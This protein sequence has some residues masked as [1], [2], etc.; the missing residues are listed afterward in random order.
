LFAAWFLICL[1]PISLLLLTL[2]AMTRMPGRSY[3]GGAPPLTE[4]Q[5]AMAG[6]M[7]AGLMELA[8]GIGPRHLLGREA[9]LDRAV[10]W[11]DGELAAMGY[12]VH[13]ERFEVEGQQ[14]A[15]LLAQRPGTGASPRC[16]VV[17]A[18]YDTVAE[19]PGAND[20][21]SGVVTTLELA[22]SFADR[23]GE[24]DL[25]FAFFVNE[26][27]PWFMGPGMGALVHARGCRERKE[28]ILGMICLECVGC[29]NDQ[30][31]SQRYPPPLE[32]L[33]PD[34]GDFVAFVGN[35]RSLLWLHRVL[36]RFRR[37]ASLPSEGLAAWEGALRDVGRSDHKAFWASG[38]PAVMITDTANFR[39]RHYHTPMDLP[40]N[41]D[42]ESMARL[43]SGLDRVIGELVKLG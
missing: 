26:E 28:R 11:I 41:V 36:A 40:A 30:P 9:K 13:R 20:N 22:R 33:Y 1:A 35:M 17:G 23:S 18:H 43:V 14:V 8:F 6:R 25:R 19:S 29:F 7:E 38:F 5:Q 27:A 10:D 37:H 24:H 2:A 16:L 15:N 3:S 42:T 31:G 34:R 39:D 4:H 12:E 21:G 32:R